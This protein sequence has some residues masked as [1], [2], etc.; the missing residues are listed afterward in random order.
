MIE[1]QLLPYDFSAL[2]PVIWPDTLFFHHEKHYTAYVTRA[3]ELLPKAWHNKSL[4][5]VVRLAWD[6]EKRD[7]FNQAAQ[8]WNHEFFFAGLSLDMADKLISSDLLFLIE[9]DFGSLEVLKQTMIDA[10]VGV[11]GAGW[12]WLVSDDGKLKIQT[13]SN[14]ETP[15]GVKGIRPLWCLDVWEHAYYLDYQNRRKAY[16]TEIVTQA[17]N[18]RFISDNLYL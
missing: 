2:K 8:V 4:D 12:M 15:C 10:A 13:T 7:L 1:I 6:K 14:A 5:E 18:W 16:V 9:R 3:N 17:I 11:F